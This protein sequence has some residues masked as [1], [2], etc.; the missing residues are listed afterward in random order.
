MKRR[1]VNASVIIVTGVNFVE[2]LM[3]LGLKI[4]NK[5]KQQVG[6]P[7][8]IKSDRG[9]SRAC[10]R[11]LFDTDGG[12]FYH[13]HWV[14]GHKYCHFGLT[15]TS[16]C[17]PLLSSFK[18]CLELDGI[19]SYGEKDCLFVYRVGDI[20][21]FFSI[22]KTRNLKHVHRFRRYLSRSTRCD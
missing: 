1:S 21:S 15:F 22:Y 13:R 8:W 19:R 7:E 2:Y 4:G 5:V 20:G 3:E 12:T 18:E 6:V 10:V 14:N 16:S 9:F 17:K 11:G